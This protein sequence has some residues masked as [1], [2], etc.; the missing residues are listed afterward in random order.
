MIQKTKIEYART[1]DWEH[2]PG[3]PL[4]WKKPVT[5]RLKGDPFE[6]LSHSYW[7]DRVFA[8]MALRPDVVFQVLT[9][10]PERMREYLTSAD[11]MYVLRSSIEEWLTEDDCRLRWPLPNAWLGTSVEDQR[12]ADV[13]IPELLATPAVIRF[14]SAEPLLGRV[15]LE[16]CD[17]INAIARDWAGGPSGGTGT[18]HPLLDWVVVGGESGP[19]ARP[20]DVAWVRSVVSQCRAAGVAV[21]VKQLGARPVTTWS[22]GDLCDR[23]LLR[24][25]KGADP[26]EWPEDLKVRSFPD[27]AAW[28]AP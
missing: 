21:F 18:P 27:V 26:A 20:C 3:A 4:R 15:D 11:R 12:W 13:R 10:R 9:K 2:H 19:G 22:N 8:V 7:L 14:V 24:D 17:G 23:L 5:A 1:W 16:W 28:V 25:R 6:P